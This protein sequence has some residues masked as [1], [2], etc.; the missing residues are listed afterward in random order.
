MRRAG[1]VQ[2]GRRSSEELTY[3]PIPTPPSFSDTHTLIESTTSQNITSVDINGKSDL[4]VGSDYDFLLFTSLNDKRVKSLDSTN[5]STWATLAK[6]GSGQALRSTSSL[7]YEFYNLRLGLQSSGVGWITSASPQSNLFQNLIVEDVDF[8]GFQ[9]NIRNPGESYGDQSIKFCRV[10][11]SVNGEGWYLGNTSAGAGIGGNRSMFNNTVIENC[12]AQDCGR[13]LFQFNGHLNLQAT[14]LTGLNGGLQN[15]PGQNACLQLYNSHGYIK[16]SIFMNATIAINISTHGFLIEDCFFYYTGNIGQ[17]FVNMATGDHTE[18][19]NHQPVIFRRC[20]FYNP[21]YTKNFFMRMD[22]PGCD[23]TFEDCVFPA[24]VTTV[25]GD[26]RSDKIT[27]TLSDTGSTFTN[28]PPIPVFGD[29]PDAA[30][31]GFEKVVTNP[32]YYNRKMG[33]RTPNT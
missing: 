17:V 18:A 33:H 12:Y 14:N 32:Y 29:S 10:L 13:E 20:T 7:N 1:I 28:T 31:S 15:I 8:A 23:L 19:V 30:Y 25:I 16:K 5:P 4:L 26:N 24:S 2:C 27:Y 22:E 6:V 11:R 3:T 21:T 9:I